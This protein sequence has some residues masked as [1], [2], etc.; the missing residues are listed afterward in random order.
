[1]N[2]IDTI[3]TYLLT[4]PIINVQWLDQVLHSEYD[5]TAPV[6][7]LVNKITVSLNPPVAPKRKKP[8]SA[9]STKKSNKKQKQTN[10][11]KKSKKNKTKKTNR[12]KKN[13]KSSKPADGDDSTDSDASDE[14]SDGPPKPKKPPTPF[15]VFMAQRRAEI[16]RLHPEYSVTEAA[17][18]MGAEWKQLSNE[19]KSKYVAPPASAESAATHPA[20]TTS[21][22]ASAAIDTNL[23]E[24]LVESIRKLL[25]TA[26]LTKLTLFTVRNELAKDPLIGTETVEQHR[27]YINHAIKQ[28]IA[29]TQVATPV[30]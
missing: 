12:S 30:C 16:K 3:K 11:S 13:G 4:S 18:A 28:C 20:K 1:M 29:A 5:N 7:Q 25:S 19:E 14:N 2:S 23:A 6:E 10:G 27:I 17:K 24:K 22:A 8:T 26:D 15:F 21:P 9:A